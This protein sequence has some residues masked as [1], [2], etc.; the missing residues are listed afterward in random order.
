MY[1]HTCNIV[2][3]EYGA[4][5]H[6]FTRPS[7]NAARNCTHSHFPTHF[8]CMKTHAKSSAVNAARNCTHSRARLLHVTGCHVMTCDGWETVEFPMF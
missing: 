3:G 6:T 7:A 2:R 8:M 5:L 4:Q 1:E